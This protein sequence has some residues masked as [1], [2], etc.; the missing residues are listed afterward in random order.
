M[1][2]GNIG[3]NKNNCV[4]SIPKK[5]SR[6]NLKKLLASSC[7]Q[8]IINE[9]SKSRE[10]NVMSLVRKINSTYN[11]VNR[12]LEILEKEGLITNSYVGNLRLIRLRRDDNRI[13]AL[14]Q[15]LR[16]LE[17]VDD[18]TIYARASL[19]LSL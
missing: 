6:M 13:V 19:P 10:I 4:Q 1:I 15:V 18:S 8:N 3:R 16:M 12:N 2:E 11:E 17:T 7:R 14:L 9:L 5:S